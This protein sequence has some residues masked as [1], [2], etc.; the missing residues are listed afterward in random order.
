MCACLSIALM[1]DKGVNSRHR[2]KEQNSL[3]VCTPKLT[4][5]R[6]TALMKFVDGNQP[7]HS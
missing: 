6:I 4:K 5:I 1:P 3:S 2:P 7:N